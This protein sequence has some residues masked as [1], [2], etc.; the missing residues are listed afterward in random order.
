VA[1]YVDILVRGYLKNAVGDLASAVLFAAVHFMQPR[2]T[3][4]PAGPE[5]DPLL[6]V[7]RLDELLGAWGDRQEATL[8]FLCLVILALALNRLRDR[9]GSLYL[10]IGLH[11]GI[12]FVL[13][14]YRRV[15]DG[16][17]VGNRWIHGGPL[18]RDGVL[19]LVG[20]LALLLAAYVAPLPRWARAGDPAA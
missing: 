20:L 9:T 18:M 17:P 19:T 14:L 4:A 15:L 2:G 3:T 7:K 10:G 5:Y 16:V 11:A 12:V 1:F 13:Q 6:A 8:G